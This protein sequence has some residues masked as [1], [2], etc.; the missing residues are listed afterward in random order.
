MLTVS[1][2]EPAIFLE[3]VR[4]WQ[5]FNTEKLITPEKFSDILCVDLGLPWPFRDAIA[6]SIQEQINEFFHRRP[7]ALNE[8]M[9]RGIGTLMEGEAARPAGPSKDIKIKGR[10][11]CH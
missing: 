11:R 1:I 5:I 10:C 2:A 3:R 8:E 4:N 9:I 7:T 6:K